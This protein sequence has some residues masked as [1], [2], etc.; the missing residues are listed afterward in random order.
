MGWLRAAV[1]QGGHCLVVA[2]LL[3]ATGAVHGAQAQLL[4]QGRR[5]YQEGILSDGQPLR[6]SGAGGT[7]LSGQDAACVQCHRR[8]G[9]GSR[10]GSLAIP[11]IAG[12]VLFGKPLWFATR[13]PG[14]NAQP[15]TG[16]RQ[17]TRAAYG[18]AS[19]ARALSEGLDSSDRELEPLMPRYALGEADMRAL[20]AYLHQLSATPPSGL[21]DGV[22]H[23]ATIVSPDADPAQAE[24]LRTTLQTWVRSAPLGGVPMDLQ[25]WNLSG[26]PAS[27]KQQLQDYQQR[28]PVYAVLSGL[29][30]AEWGPV[31]DFCEQAALPCLFPMADLAPSAPSDFYTLYFS[32]GVPLEAQMLARHIRDL[33]QPAPRVIQVFSDGAGSA[34]AD[35]LQQGLAQDR[36]GS[37]RPWLAQS[38]ASAL[39]DVQPDD[40]VVLW[41]RPAE[42]AELVRALP[43]GP[44]SS[45]VY[46]SAQLT[47]PQ[48]LNLPAP[49]RASTRWVSARSD[50]ARLYGKSVMGLVPWASH[51][52]LA[53]DDRALL[54]EIYAA[55][56]FFAD[57]LARMRGSWSQDYLMETLENANFS[58]P[59]GSAFF[60]LSLAAGQREAAKGGHLLGYA[61]PGDAEV[62]AMGPRITP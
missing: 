12:P 22:L 27:W 61:E 56:Y 6:A 44:A 26:P 40:C 24:I 47:G 29:G 37:L 52:K 42:V 43:M 11:A 34:A 50:P 4:E 2:C 54:S 41:L 20:T 32:R 16:T 31:R 60:T 35:L 9:M 48:Q 49:W 53:L 3:L 28:Q 51:L 5:I 58:R 18:D 23:V 38:P 13:R 33:A 45:Q 39:A 17:E 36:P 46:I 1:R 55:T 8:S 30:R 15:V 57:A 62:Q 59:A 21:E 10:E 7:R 14:A 19:L 25:L